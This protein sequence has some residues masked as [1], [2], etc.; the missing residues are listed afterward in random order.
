LKRLVFG[1]VLASAFSILGS[2][3]T[4]P[5]RA[6]PS[7][8]TQSQKSYAPA[9]TPAD[10]VATARK[11]L[12]A[13]YAAYGDTPSEGF[14]CL[15]FVI[16]VFRQLGIF[17]PYDMYGAWNSAPHV[18]PNDL[19]PGDILFFSNTVYA[20]LSHVAIYIGNG[21]MIGADNYAVGVTID[22]VNDPYWASRYT[23]A[24]RPLALLGAAPGPIVHA[25]QVSPAAA[26][27]AVAIHTT[28]PVG[29]TVQPVSSQIGLYSGPGYQYTPLSTLNPTTTLS[30]VQV[31]GGWYKV[32]AGAT[33]G[34]VSAASVRAV[35][36]PLIQRQLTAR[37]TALGLNALAKPRVSMKDVSLR[38][39]RATAQVGSGIQVEVQSTRRNGRV[40][41]IH[42]ASLGAG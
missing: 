5:S 18:A 34:W 10:I 22:N 11:Y 21:Q 41:R 37:V 6:N 3:P 7:E 42:P 20:G 9:P 16:F 27:A 12:G 17:V 15:G 13:P 39:A 28:L 25:G 35:P 31:E 29:S 30:I 14:S 38:F 19:M 36:S 8:N 2:F 23:G 33:S 40:V 24:T 32:H 26:S 1:I 4:S